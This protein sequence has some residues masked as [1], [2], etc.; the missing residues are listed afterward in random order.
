M[1]PEEKIA[2]RFLIEQNL[3]RIIYEPKG[4]RT[5]DFSINNEIGVEVRRLNKH[6]KA[7]PL[8]KL[9]FDIIPKLERL[10][11]SYNEGFYIK[12]YF[13]NI[14]FKRPLKATKNVLGR[15]KSILDNHSEEMEG[16][17]EYEVSDNLT[18]AIIPSTDR[19]DHKFVFG[20]ST[21]FDRAGFPISDIIDSLNIIIPE[22]A[23]IVEPHI[24]DF[25]KWWLILVDHIGYVPLE[26][27]MENLR[28]NFSLT[29]PFE[30]IYLISPIDP[31]RGT[32]L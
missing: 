15:V 29:L 25:K 11:K 28:K 7:T 17:Y 6:L 19:F 10:F 4:Q 14:S 9:Q 22:K 32:L 24:N 21:D 20:S 30:R 2:E 3:G 18:I 5:P 27:E 8:E 13:V 12:S 31:K 23:R 16:T 1:K 26:I